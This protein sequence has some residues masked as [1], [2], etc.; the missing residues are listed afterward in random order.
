M[1]SISPGNAASAFIGSGT[2]S[3]IQFSTRSVDDAVSAVEQSY[4]PHELALKTVHGLDMRFAGFDVGRLWVSHIEYGC[5]AVARPQRPNEYWMFSYIVRGESRV[6]GEPVNAGT[7]CVRAPGTMTDVP[8]SAD[9][10]LVNLKVDAAELRAAQTT[11]LGGHS[12]ETQRFEERVA[13]GTTPAL[14]FVN[15]LQRLHGLPPSPPQFA[16]LLER[17]WQEAALFELLLT[18]PGSLAQRPERIP[19]SRSAVDR[20]LDLIHADLSAGVTL[21]DIARGAG[22]GVRALSRGFE[23][24]LGTSPMRYLQQRRLERA[25]SDLLDGNG[26]VTEIAYRWGFSNLGDFAIR[27][28]QHFGERPS[29]TLRGARVR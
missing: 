5:P 28:R 15:L 4:G 26:N 23:R 6:G 7:V 8:M 18:L 20:A 3:G 29:Q 21:G 11:L 24:R 9:L 1:T 14:Q 27:Y 13:A 25:R 19:A 2:R 10:R 17:R 12:G 22:V 16:A